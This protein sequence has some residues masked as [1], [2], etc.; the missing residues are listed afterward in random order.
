M[1]ILFLVQISFEKEVEGDYTYADSEH[2]IVIDVRLQDSTC[3]LPKNIEIIS[4]NP[5]RNS[6]REIVSSESES[7]LKSG[8][9]KTIIL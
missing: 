6:G 8:E 7:N 5:F 3:V 9:R 2:K 1:L 4:V